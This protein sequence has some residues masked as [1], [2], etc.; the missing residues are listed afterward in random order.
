MLGD[1]K[2]DAAENGPGY[3]FVLKPDDTFSFI[4]TITNMVLTGSAWQIFDATSEPIPRSA[5]DGGLLYA[6][7]Q[8][9]L[10][11]PNGY[12]WSIGAFSCLPC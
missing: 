10:I 4:S 5:G 9:S 7:A 8:C 2:V 6:A 3:A 1:P 12:W 11:C